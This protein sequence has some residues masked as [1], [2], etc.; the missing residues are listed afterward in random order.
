[1]SLTKKSLFFLVA[2]L[3][4]GCGHTPLELRQLQTR[5]YE[6]VSKKRLVAALREICLDNAGSF[7]D[8]TG[9]DE[10]S[11]TAACNGYQKEK[12]LKMEL[13]SS[14]VS[15]VLR[16]RIDMGTR[17]IYDFYYTNL[18]SKISDQLVLNQIP[19]EVKKSR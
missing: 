5:V 15:T 7:F 3:L 14:S 8:L 10:D 18:F 19:V 9:L 12:Y 17:K 2:M 16:V 4:A 6:N 1:M 13:T 11:G